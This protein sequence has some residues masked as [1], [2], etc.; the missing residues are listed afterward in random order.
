[1]TKRNQEEPAEIGWVE[2]NELFDSPARE[3]A[4]RGSERFVYKIMDYVYDVINSNCKVLG[5]S[6]PAKVNWQTK[7]DNNERKTWE[8]LLKLSDM[9][10][11]SMIPGYEDCDTIKIISAEAALLVRLFKWEDLQKSKPHKGMKIDPQLAPTMTPGAIEYMKSIGG[12]NISQLGFFSL[13]CAYL[14]FRLNRDNTYKERRYDVFDFIS[15]LGFIPKNE[16]TMTQL[17]QSDAEGMQMPFKLRFDDHPFA[18]HN[19]LEE[20]QKLSWKTYTRDRSDGITESYYHLNP[21]NSLI[22]EKHQ[23]GQLYVKCLRNIHDSGKFLAAIHFLQHHSIIEAYGLRKEEAWLRTFGFYNYISDTIS[24]HFIGTFIK[25]YYGNKDK[26]P[27]VIESRF[28]QFLSDI[29]HI[30]DRIW[31]LQ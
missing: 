24:D 2:N 13:E 7:T 28:T 31:K 16:V 14:Q 4:S 6:S 26:S 23:P 29:D 27:W 5:L 22:S 17:T 30:A 20:K 19:E 21:Q 11:S 8:C 10:V 9:N 3:D 25:D 18:V 12:E 1:M 15:N